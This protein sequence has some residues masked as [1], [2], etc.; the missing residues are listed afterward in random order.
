MRRVSGAS[1]EAS[2]SFTTDQIFWPGF[3]PSVG[4][5]TETRRA[6]LLEVRLVFVPFRAMQQ[7]MSER[8][9]SPPFSSSHISLYFWLG[10]HVFMMQTVM[11]S[12]SP[13]RGQWRWYQLSKTK[14]VNAWSSLDGGL[15]RQAHPFLIEIMEK[16]RNLILAQSRF[17]LSEI[18]NADATITG[19]KLPYSQHFKTYGTVSF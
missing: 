7:M 12:G 4:C 6:F 14:L 1:S 2:V 15:V 9:L 18:G 17:T 10:S 3:F 8:A 19:S 13:E 11:R 16:A 5:S